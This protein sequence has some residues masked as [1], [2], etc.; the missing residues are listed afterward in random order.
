MSALDAR[1]ILRILISI[2][3]DLGKAGADGVIGR[4]TTAAIT[5]F[6]AS[7]GSR[8]NGRARSGR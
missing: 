6:Q 3:Y 2:G 7:R 8:S 1:A 5:A 4:L